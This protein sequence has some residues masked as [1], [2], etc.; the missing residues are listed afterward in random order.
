MFQPRLQLPDNFGARQR[1]TR[2]AS[3]LGLSAQRSA[4]A[5]PL[6]HAIARVPHAHF[7][8]TVLH[9][10]LTLRRPPFDTQIAPLSS[11]DAPRRGR[12]MSLSPKYCGYVTIVDR[13]NASHAQFWRRHT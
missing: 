10:P 8:D 1:L 3:S 13:Q 4:Y 9:T 2:V 11:V 12:G 6:A 5:P 7:T